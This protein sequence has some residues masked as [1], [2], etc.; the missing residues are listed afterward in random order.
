MDAY[1][2]WFRE[3][4]VPLVVTERIT[5]A[6]DVGETRYVGCAAFEGEGNEVRFYEI[7]DAY[8]ADVRQRM[9]INRTKF[10]ETLDLFYSRDFY[11]ARN[12]FMEILKDCP[13]DGVARWY[14]FECEKYMNGEGDYTR[15]GY[16]QLEKK[17]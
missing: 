14:I 16:I 9:L 4:G 5:R 1:A 3:L 11:L 2:S 6:E 8:P 15:S 7:L 10:Q 12:Q 13:Q 17:D